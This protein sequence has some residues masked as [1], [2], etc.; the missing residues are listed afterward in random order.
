MLESTSP[1]ENLREAIVSNSVEGFFNALAQ[2]AD[3]NCNLDPGC[4][5]LHFAIERGDLTFA[6]LLINRGADVK[7]QDSNGNTALHYAARLGDLEVAEKLI[8][9]GADVDARNRDG[10]TPLWT[11]ARFGRPEV[12]SRISEVTDLPL[13]EHKTI[14]EE[15]IIDAMRK[16]NLSTQ[17]CLNFVQNAFKQSMKIAYADSP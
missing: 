17:D 5:A 15:G 11:A 3:I 13:K 14:Y 6:N 4:P 7:S 1:N 10:A 9:S 16:G 2:G 12:F 8:A